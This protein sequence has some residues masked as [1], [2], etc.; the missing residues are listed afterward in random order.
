MD[1]V[2]CVCVLCQNN[3]PTLRDT[4]HLHTTYSWFKSPKPINDYVNKKNSTGFILWQVETLN[5]LWKMSRHDKTNRLNWF[6]QVIIGRLF[7]SFKNTDNHKHYCNLH[8]NVKLA[9][10]NFERFK[11]CHWTFAQLSCR[12]RGPDGERIQP[13]ECLSC[14]IETLYLPSFVSG[15]SSHFVFEKI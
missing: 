8:W 5:L 15:I 9:L 4:E 3:Q 14:H 13:V 7:S 6:P 11:K 2:L 12:S 1:F 10:S